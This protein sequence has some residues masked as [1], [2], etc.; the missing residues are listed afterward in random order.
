MTHVL[1]A[2]DDN[3]TS[4]AAAR[5]ALRLFGE[6]ADYT[7]LNVAENVPVKWGDDAL[8]YGMV[9][10]LSVPGAG[11]IGGVPF[12]VRSTD[13]NDRTTDRV[14]AAQQTA[15]E[16]ARDAGITSA[17]AVGDTGDPADAII[18]AARSQGAD[19]VVVG[20]HE[21]GWFKRLF[22]SSVSDAVI[23]DAEIPVLV[24]R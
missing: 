3:D 4:V 2:V 8:E 7:V 20:T 15:D 18:T 6:D 17:K 24:A 23:R 22:A 10:P 5:T 9:Y 16:L 13:M 1:I 11:V 19:V 14:E 21:R 12:V